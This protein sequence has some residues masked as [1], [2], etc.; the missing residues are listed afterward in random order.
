MIKNLHSFYSFSGVTDSSRL[1]YGLGGWAWFEIQ[2]VTLQRACPRRYAFVMN[3]VSLY[4]A[5]GELQRSPPN[6]YAT[7]FLGERHDPVHSSSYEECL[8]AGI[9]EFCLPATDDVLTKFLRNKCYPSME[10][11][12]ILGPLVRSL[13]IFSPFMDMVPLDVNESAELP[14]SLENLTEEVIDNMSLHF[15]CTIS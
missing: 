4:I 6:W 1:P 5:Q 7:A 10:S 12:A 8:G 14:R 2:M 11:R 13:S 9:S 3:V 15:F